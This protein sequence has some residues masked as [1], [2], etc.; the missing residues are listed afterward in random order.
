M[1]V[2]VVRYGRVS[3]A[4]RLYVWTMFLYE[5]FDDHG[6][7][8][9]CPTRRASDLDLERDGI[10][11][12]AWPGGPCP[13]CGDEMPARLVHCRSCRAMLNSELTEDSIVIPDFFM[14]PEVTDLKSA[15]S[16]GCYIPCPGCRS[17]E[18]RLNSS[19]ITIS[20]AVFFFKKKTFSFF[21]FFFF[22]FS[23]SRPLNCLI[24]PS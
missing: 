7:L 12:G 15:A 18:Q 23:E 17:E 21:F 19:H 20:Y 2:V 13:Q 11:N 3:I 16:R 14:L 5:W 6:D 4:K 9:S 10:M 8:H 22:L 1:Y 24:H